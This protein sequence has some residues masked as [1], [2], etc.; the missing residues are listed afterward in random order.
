MS[1]VYTNIRFLYRIL[2]QPDALE[3]FL[4]YISPNCSDPLMFKHTKT[5]IN[6]LMPMNRLS[7]NPMSQHAKPHEWQ[8][9][10]LGEED[11]PYPG[12]HIGKRVAHAANDKILKWAGDLHKGTPL[13]AWDHEAVAEESIG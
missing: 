7:D 12:R 6:V 1:V 10:R 4:Q 11:P 2:H 13:C 3:S 5:Y 8:R 9:H